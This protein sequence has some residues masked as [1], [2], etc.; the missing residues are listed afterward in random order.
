MSRPFGTALLLA[1]HDDVNGYQLYFSDPSGTFT[2]YKA[3]A[4]GAGSE[5]AQSNLSESYSDSLTLAEAENLA[6]GTL[7]AVMEEKI[8]SGNVELAVVDGTGFRLK[9]KEEVEEVLGRM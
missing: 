3:K 2:S 5:G 8:A 9:K 6:L 4:I 7:K 1:G